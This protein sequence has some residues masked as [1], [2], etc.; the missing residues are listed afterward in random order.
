MRGP[1]DSP[2]AET[3]A[4]DL[5][6]GLD[7]Q[8]QVAGRLDEITQYWKH[9]PQGDEAQVG[10]EQLGRPCEVVRTGIADVDPGA[11][12]DARVAC[13][14]LGQLTV[15]N[16]KSHHLACAVPQQDLRESAG[17]GPHIEA[18]LVC[19]AQTV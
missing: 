1:D 8:H 7:Q 12:G 15:P 2:L 10:D 13:D 9:E 3:F 16:V 5:E 14:L 17:T 11:F 6:L 4:A 18:P 19:S